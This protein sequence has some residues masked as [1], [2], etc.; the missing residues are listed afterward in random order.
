MKLRF[1]TTLS[2]ILVFSAL[3][4]VSHLTAFRV[5]DEVLRETV[6]SQEIEKTR[7]VSRIVEELLHSEVEQASLTAKLTARRN[8]LGR[9]LA[10]PDRDR[11]E[12]MQ[13]VLDNALLASQ[14][15]FL[16]VT[17]A[18]ETVIYRAHDPGR[19]GD[20]ATTWGVHEALAGAS[21]VASAQED[22][23]V[24]LHAIE[25]VHHQ[26]QVVGTVSA[27]IKLDS[28][29]LKAISTL[30][31]AQ[32]S[33]VS[34]TGKVWAYTGERVAQLETKAIQEALTQK[35]PV[36]RQDAQTLRTRIYLPVVIV[37][38][39]YAIVAEIDSSAALE[40]LEAANWRSAG[41]TVAILLLSLL[42]GVLVLRRLMKPLRDLRIKAENSAVELTGAPIR[43]DLDDEI[44]AV[45]HALETL[46]ERLLRRNAELD[47]ARAAAEAATVAKSEFLSNM[48]HEIRTPLNGVLG[49]A[50]VLQRTPLTTEQARYLDAI[51][52]AGKALHAVLG[53][54]LDLA[55]VEAGR[56]SLEQVDFDLAPILYH[57]GDIYGELAAGQGSLFHAD[58]APAALT[59]VKGDPTRVHQ[60][61]SNLLSNAV[62]FTREGSISLSGEALPSPAGDPRRWLRFTVSDT[63]VGMAPE[64]IERLFKPFTQ[65]D[66]ST[67]RL[68]GGTGLGL[69]I[70]RHLVEL[71]GGTITVDSAPQKGSIFRVDLPF[72]QA[73]SA[74][75]SDQRPE[76]TL[77]F[78]G[79]RF[80]VAEDNLVNQAVVKA[81][82]AQLG[83]D[84]VI[85]S[86][87]TAAV[88]Y[89][90][91]EA[92]DLVLMDCQMPHMDG[93]QATAAI[94]AMEGEG[95]R[96][97]IIAVTANAQPEDR[98]RCLD[99]GMDDYL[100]KPI[101]REPL[102]AALSR[103]LPPESQAAAPPAAAPTPPSAAPAH[104]PVAVAPAAGLP[105]ARFSLID[106][107]ALIDNPDFS[108]PAS[109]DLRRRV[110]RLYLIETPRQVDA[111]IAGLASGDWPVVVRAAHTI[112]SSSATIGAAGLAAKALAIETS[113]RRQ[114][115]DDVNRQ[116][117]EFQHYVALVRQEVE[118]LEDAVSRL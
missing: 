4:T 29:R 15:D 58:F 68:Y 1:D 86:D 63:G 28:R 94:R 65:A 96:T 9:S 7:M 84:P 107:Q 22:G 23:L 104:P 38:N 81:M 18:S 59:R 75:A 111:L 82:L 31:A 35:I 105:A 13:S 52:T 61:L 109:D 39:A 6:R 102:V 103:W 19:Q 115:T 97:P 73:T 49:M 77:G 17:N 85:A 76:A 95:R 93:Y 66:A 21:M 3:A 50:E 67:T 42:A 80:L 57:L 92:F 20:R 25:P 55:K 36:F 24:T 117:P 69:T 78:A 106:R 33:L 90:S 2:L 87:G 40:K 110:I 47:E 116:L 62:K 71:M 53:D 113:A 70:C 45:V 43:S 91:K 48:S 10:R 79:R 99:A 83:A 26:G 27:G 30:V 16:E 41:Y 114:D 37:D 98:Q 14:M 12:T 88:E 56:L 8:S 11:D 112:K 100:S 108:G 60:V 44:P 34:S 89:F 101:R 51:V 46:T 32:L 118:A 72:V 54:V 74:S 5:S 64:A